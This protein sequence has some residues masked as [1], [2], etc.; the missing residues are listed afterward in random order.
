MG[1]AEYTTTVRPGWFYALESEPYT[2]ILDHKNKVMNY[3]DAQCSVGD[4]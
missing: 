3:K 4:L 1:T 2:D